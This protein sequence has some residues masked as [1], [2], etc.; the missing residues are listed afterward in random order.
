MT[1]K[2]KQ[3]ITAM[4]AAAVAAAMGDSPETPPKSR[5]RKAAP[6]VAATCITAGIAWELLG[7]DESFKPRDPDKPATNAQLWR[8]NAAGRLS[9]S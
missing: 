6:K 2:Q 8:L 3:E 7:A 1:A 4:V 5:G 9:V